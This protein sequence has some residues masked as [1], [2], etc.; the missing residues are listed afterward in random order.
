MSPTLLA[1]LGTSAPALRGEVPVDPDA[2]T[3]RRWL[4]EELALPEYST[5]PSLLERFLKWLGDL[6]DG[7][8]SLDMDPLTAAVV[9]V[10]A[11]LVV[12]AIA[13]YV[14]GPVR[15][16]RRTRIAGAV[17]EDDERDAAEL[18]AAADA[19]AAAGDWATA[20]VERFRAVVRSLEERVVLE[21]QPG[22]TAHEA[23]ASAA[24]RI[25]G[26]T[27][28]LEQ[29]ARLFDDVLYGKVTVGPD[30]DQVLRHLDSRALAARP[31]PAAT[32]LAG[33]GR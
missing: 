10:V 15:L 21:P 31:E 17:F 5:G 18:R 32:G 30:A 14:A 6:F 22:R 2:S 9:I 29:G 28:E 8:P 7:A 4:L 27:A 26:L 12:G 24:Q 11:L 3:A 25:P 1:S 19:A 33:A 20:V 23:A 13:Y 16:S